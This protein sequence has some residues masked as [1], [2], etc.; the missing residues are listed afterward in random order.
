MH[1][2]NN[3]TKWAWN[4]KEKHGRLPK[5]KPPT[6]EEKKPN[7]EFKNTGNRNKPW[8]QRTNNDKTKWPKSTKRKGNNESNK[9]GVK[10][11]IGHGANQGNVRWWE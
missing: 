2:D 6:T 1:I 11:S 3:K 4:G 10:T 8:P 5:K 9:E 7:C